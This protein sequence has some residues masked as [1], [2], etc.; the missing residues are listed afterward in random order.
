MDD[1]E[2][3]QEEIIDLYNDPEFGLVGKSAFKKKLLQERG[4]YATM[5]DINKALQGQDSYT[6][7]KP[8]QKKFKNR[9]VVVFH[10]FEQIQMDLVFMD[11]PNAAPAKDNKGFKY[12]LTAIDVLSKYAWAIPLKDKTAVSTAKAMAIIINF[13]HPKKIQVDKGSEFYNATVKKLLAANGVE[14]F[15]TE[16]DKKASVVERFNRTLKQRMTKLFDSTNDTKYIDKLDDMVSNYN[17]TV[18][19]TIKMKPIDAIK[20]KNYTTLLKNY[21]EKKEIQKNKHTPK[22]KVGDYVR[23]PK[24]KSIFAK[25]LAG[26]WTIE[27]FK[28]RKVQN[29]TPFTYL[30]ED[31]MGEDVTGAFYENELQHVDKNIVDTARVNKILKKRTFKGVKEVFVSWEGYPIC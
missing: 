19:S 10:V 18:H 9:N 29:T 31:L 8:V 3:R 14:L 5:A 4:I 24:W 1:E 20:P 23:I 17:N 15:S 16:S 21:Y 11:T 25:E 2:A 12:I 28:I 22:Y 7:N 13:A 27:V 6:L 26:N 30:I